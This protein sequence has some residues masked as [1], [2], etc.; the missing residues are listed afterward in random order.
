MNS[1]SPT[2]VL[3]AVGATVWWTDPAMHHGEEHTSGL[4][5]VAEAPKV[6]EDYSLED[7]IEDGIYL[8]VNEH[9]GECEALHQEIRLATAEDMQG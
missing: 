4:F 8:L 9:G 6:D 3:F 7:A 5:K 2:Q 1:N